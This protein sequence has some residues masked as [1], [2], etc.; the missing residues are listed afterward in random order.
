MIPRQHLTFQHIQEE[1]PEACPQALRR[2]RWAVLTIDGA[3]VGRGRFDRVEP[4]LRI[5]SLIYPKSTDANPTLR[6][7]CVRV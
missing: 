3:A 7:P 2:G 5:L 1:F 6:H 4:A